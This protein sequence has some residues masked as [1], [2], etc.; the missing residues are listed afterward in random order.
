M[1]LSGIIYKEWIKLRWVLLGSLLIALF[2][3]GYVFLTVQH[4]LKFRSPTSYWNMVL[5]MSFSYYGYLKFIPLLIGLGM[6]ITQFFPETINKRIKL[7]F[8]LPMNENQVLMQMVLFGFICLFGISMFQLV[9]FII[10]SN[11]FFPVE[12]ITQA[13]LSLIPWVL[14]GWFA[15]LWTTFL[16]LEP[17]WRKRVQY[18][19]IGIAC[20]FM[21]LIPAVMGAILPVIPY[22]LLIV[23]F[24]FP[25]IIY[26]G[27][28]FRKGAA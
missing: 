25:A 14:A 8:H 9:I 4:D 2:A 11:L 28:R 23:I 1:K 17:T 21:F 3:T 19:I 27:Y 10:F 20:L 5:F 18:G 13:T 26:S 7:T 22:Y 12:I 15:Y 24:C 16:V 6:A